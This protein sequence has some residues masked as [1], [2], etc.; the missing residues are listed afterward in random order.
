MEAI[1]SFMVERN[2]GEDRHNCSADFKSLGSRP[3]R[4]VGKFLMKCSGRK[5]GQFRSG[6]LLVGDRPFYF[7]M[8]G[9][10]R[11]NATQSIATVFGCSSFGF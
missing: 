6:G 9:R 3:H 4:Q 8:P 2:D 11:L 10:P 5:D 7:Q 1:P